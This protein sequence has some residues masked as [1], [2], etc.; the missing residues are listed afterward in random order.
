MNIDDKAILVR[1]NIGM[2]GKGRQDKEITAEVIEE[3]EMKDKA[4][5]WIKELY[6]PNAFAPFVKVMGEART[7]LYANSLPWGDDGNRILPVQN[8]WQFTKGI[9]EIKTK[10]EDLVQTLLP[11]EYPK[12]VAWAEVAHG[13]KFDPALYPGVDYLKAKFRFKVDVNPVPTANDF[14]VQLAQDE[15]DEIKA[16]LEKRINE[17]TAAARKDLWERLLKPIQHMAD[18]L[19]SADAKFKD[20]LVGNIREITA[21]IPNLNLTG[22]KD[23]LRAAKEVSDTLGRKNP[24]TLR[25]NAT[26]RTE[27]AK[28]AAE[29]V[30]KLQGYF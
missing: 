16:D 15:L 13:E 9:R 25:E 11:V 6:P 3:K 20:S 8:H 24:D 5:K 7:F 26:A 2:P 29:M 21:L 30:A 17:A 19:Q 10:F 4:G 18:K 14:R 12:W 27:A 1:L 28:Q 23:L 22:D